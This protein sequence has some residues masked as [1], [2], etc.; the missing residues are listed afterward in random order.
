MPYTIRLASRS[1]EK[2]LAAVP[3]D[4]RDFVVTRIRNLAEQPRAKGIK[5]LARDVY[6]LRIRRYRVIYKIL[7]KEEAILIGKVALRTER[8]Y[9]GL[10]ELF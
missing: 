2:Q 7:E 5:T 8:T 6:R 9:K 10:E 4:D 3:Q 1:V